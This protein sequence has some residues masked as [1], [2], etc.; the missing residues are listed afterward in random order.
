MYYAL[1]DRRIDDLEGY[2]LSCDE[3]G[4]FLARNIPLVTR[5]FSSIGR[6]V[7]KIRSVSEMGWLL[8]KAYGAEL[9][10]S[11]QIDGLQ[12][13]ANYMTEGRWVLAKIAAVQL[14]FPE[15][16]DDAAV[17]KVIAAEEYL[18]KCRCQTGT[19]KNTGTRDVSTEPRV[20]AGQTGGG[21]WTTEE[22]FAAGPTNSLLIPAQAIAPPVPIPAPFEL[23]MPPTGLNPPYL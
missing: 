9:D 12:R 6:A 7:Y 20:T 16:P 23:P 4:V 2:G 5:S 13:I 17:G 15:L 18:A 10:L 8:A 14:C 19:S 22:G 11:N 1:C 3:E 21:Q